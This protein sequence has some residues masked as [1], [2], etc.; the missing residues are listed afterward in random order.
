MVISERR[1]FPQIIDESVIRMVLK[2]CFFVAGAD[3]D[4]LPCEVGSEFLLSCA[5]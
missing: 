5:L 4:E 2:V 1:S 3:V